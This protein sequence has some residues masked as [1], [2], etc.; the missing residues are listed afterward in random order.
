MID[1]FGIRKRRKL[2]REARA[3][4]NQAQSEMDADFPG[5]NLHTAEGIDDWNGPAIMEGR[6]DNSYRMPSELRNREN[7]SKTPIFRV[8]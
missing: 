8:R 2:N 3:I 1:L 6:A 4:W 7:S 5:D